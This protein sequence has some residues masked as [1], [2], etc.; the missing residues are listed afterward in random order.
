[1]PPEPVFEESVEV[2]KA[3]AAKEIGHVPMP[4]GLSKTSR[5][6]GKILEE[7]EARRQEAL[8]S[9]YAWKTPRFTVPSAV[10]R[11]K[12]VNA[13]TLGLQ[14]AGH[15]SSVDTDDLSIWVSIGDSG[16]SLKLAAVGHKRPAH[17]TNPLG[18]VDDKQERLQIEFSRTGLDFEHAGPWQDQPDNPLES[19]LTVIATEILVYGELA[20]RAQLMH[21]RQWALERLREREAAERAERQKLEAEECDRIAKLERAQLDYLLVLATRLAQSEQIRA[22]V[23]AMGRRETEEPELRQWCEW[24]SG[25]ADKLDPRL[26][27]TSQLFPPPPDQTSAASRSDAL[28]GSARAGVIRPEALP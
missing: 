12:L 18:L 8:K 5:P 11:L 3:R 25:I 2:V 22:L 15:Y 7:E 26:R 28:D 4:R 17:H 21:R 10:R 16:A 9:P 23:Q 14:N 20:H 27:P 24:A 19:Q 6:I 1:V 13:L